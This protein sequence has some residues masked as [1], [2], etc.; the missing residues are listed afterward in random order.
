M[1]KRIILLSCITAV[2]IATFVGTKALEPNAYENGLLAQNVEALSQGDT[3]SGEGGDPIPICY[4]APSFLCILNHQLPHGQKLTLIVRDYRNMS[5]N[6][7]FYDL[8]LNP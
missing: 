8:L 4:S 3:N 5:S 6:R 1:R 2:A 7:S